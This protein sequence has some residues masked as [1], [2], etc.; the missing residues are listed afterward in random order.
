MRKFIQKKDYTRPE[1]SKPRKER[2]A[3]LQEIEEAA[4]A[5]I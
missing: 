4:Y 5:I 1:Q 2:C 3:N